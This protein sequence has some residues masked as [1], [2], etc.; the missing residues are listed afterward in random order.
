MVGGGRPYYLKCWAKLTH[1]FENGDFQ[2]ICAPYAYFQSIFAPYASAILPGEKCSKPLSK[3]LTALVS[4]N[5]FLNNQLYLLSGPALGI[6][7]VLVRTGP[8][9][10]GVAN[11]GTLYLV[12]HQMSAQYKNI[13]DTKVEKSILCNKSCD[14][15]KVNS[16]QVRFSED[17]GF[18]ASQS[19]RENSCFRVCTCIG[20]HALNDGILTGD[21]PVLCCAALRQSAIVEE[22]NA[23]VYI[24]S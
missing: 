17:I 22:C 7:E 9:I 21:C 24:R 5:P 13:N 11:F 16:G 23:S 4:S 19:C 14:N 15:D 20:L 12:L 18:K 1:P 10:L 3:C 6:F 8:P 2:S